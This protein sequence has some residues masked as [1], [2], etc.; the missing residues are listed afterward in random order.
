MAAA[1]FFIIPTGA[2]L[3]LAGFITDY[4]N[5]WGWDL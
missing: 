5:F 3:A 4:F 1:L 2:V